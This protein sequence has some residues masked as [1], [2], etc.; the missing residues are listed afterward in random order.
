MPELLWDASA[1][2]KRYWVEN[3][4]ETVERLFRL[5]PRTRMAVTVLG[6]AE[7]FAI[8]VRKRNA[9]L[10]GPDTFRDARNNLYDDAFG[11]GSLNLFDIAYSD[12]PAGTALIERHNINSSDAA[13][14][15]SYI[16]QR[17]R[18]TSEPILVASDNRLLRAARVEGFRTLNP[19][20][21]APL[22]LHGFLPEF[23]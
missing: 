23:F 6:Y 8:L 13:I 10:L 21:V 5:V 19:E 2:V 16:H 14:L 20:T 11:P 22:D 18:L 9:R 15:A 17:P 1:L 4:A 12:V 3:G 7:T